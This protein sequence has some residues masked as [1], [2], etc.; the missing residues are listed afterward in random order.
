MQRTWFLHWLEVKKNWF[1]SLYCIL[2]AT[3]L[4]YF[5]YQLLISL[6]LDCLYLNA[7]SRSFY[8]WL[9]RMIV[10]PRFSWNHGHVKPC[11]N[12]RWYLPVPRR[13]FGTGRLLTLL[14]PFDFSKWQ[15]VNWF[16]WSEHRNKNSVTFVPFVPSAMSIK[17]TKL[18]Y[19]SSCLG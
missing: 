11:A 13:L 7:Q 18:K 3:A 14:L 2:T 19:C 9:V 15:N 12:A 6:D 16:W 8:N 1:L 17:S 5:C 10:E 4:N